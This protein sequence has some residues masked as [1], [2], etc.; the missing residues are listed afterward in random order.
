M[1][2]ITKILNSL[3]IIIVIQ[4]TIITALSYGWNMDNLSTK[5]QN[6]VSVLDSNA[7]ENTK[8]DKKIYISTKEDMIQFMTRVN[9]GESLSGYTVELQND[10]NL[11]CNE[12]NPWTPIG[13]DKYRFSG[14]FEGNGHSIS[15]MNI[16]S[17]YKYVG[18]FGYTLGEI[19]NLTVKNS[20]I[21]VIEKSNES[22]TQTYTQT[23]MGM[24][25]GYGSIINN[26]YTE[27]CNINSTIEES[28]GFYYYIGGIAGGCSNVEKVNSKTNITL[29]IIAKPYYSH[30]FVGG[31]LGRGE[32]ICDS[33]NEGNINVPQNAGAIGGIVGDNYSNVK[34]CYNMGNV[35][36]SGVNGYNCCRHTEELLEEIMEEFI[37]VT[38][39]EKYQL[40][41]M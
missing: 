36:T 24:I 22:T 13:N 18:L 9:S 8:E 28:N 14:T 10:I 25:L 11:N 31:V 19:K 2:K 16:S 29:D 17:S 26:C 40:L 21:N 33:S 38:I 3:L 41:V 7:N 37:L 15:G 12:N 6:E 30:N 35:T 34:K 39:V 20:T 32:K 27:N 4:L 23:Y 5:S 1:C